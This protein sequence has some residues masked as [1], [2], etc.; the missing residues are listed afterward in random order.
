M[1][2][3]LKRE[4]APIT[5]QAWQVIDDEARRVINR[6]LCGRKLVDFSGPHGLDFSA[7]N[8]GRLELSDEKEQFGIRWGTRQVQPLVE[9]R[10][11]F[12]L[13]KMEIDS[14]NRGCK[15]PD[16]GPLQHAAEKLARFEDKAIFNGFKAGQIEGLFQSVTQKAV[17]LPADAG[18]YPKAIASALKQITLI[19]ITGPFSLALG[20]DEYF[21]LLQTDGKGYPPRKTIEDMLGGE[22]MLSP[23]IVGGMLISVR[24]GDFE[25]A[26]GQDFSIGYNS[27]D[28]E[29]VELFITESFTFRTI[30]PAAAVPLK[31]KK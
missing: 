22:I 20:P 12:V 8:T 30:E 13:K 6:N 17:S 27:Q 24:G 16:L 28:K 3:I 14:V 19:G 4:F 31:T 2:D 10:I 29:S 15:D 23:A 25:L 5:E 7:V 26:V 21:A 18:S 1:S 9:V 11:P